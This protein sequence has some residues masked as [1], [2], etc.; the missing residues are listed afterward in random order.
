MY[1]NRMT[2]HVLCAVICFMFY[3]GLALLQADPAAVTMNAGLNGNWYGGP[4]RNFEGFNL[5]V[6]PQAG[7]YVLVVNMYAY[8][9]GGNP[10][11]V[12]GRP[13]C[14][15]FRNEHERVYL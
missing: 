4:E 6:S 12:G 14:R 9:S 13:G 10:L 8:A 1:T 11:V 3:P 7:G 15:Q 2:K 5:E